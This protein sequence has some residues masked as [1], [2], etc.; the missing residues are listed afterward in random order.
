MDIDVKI[1]ISKQ[2][3]KV[4]NIEK[5]IPHNKYE[6]KVIME[7]KMYPV[8]YYKHQPGSVVVDET[9][10]NIKTQGL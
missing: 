10:T 6:P 1:N 7:D 2:G 5:K 8:M 3:F 9:L 4:K